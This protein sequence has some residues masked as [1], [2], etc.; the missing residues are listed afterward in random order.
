VLN[1]A[2]QAKREGGRLE[3]LYLNVDGRHM[4]NVTENEKGMVF[5]Q[6]IELLGLSPSNIVLEIL[7]GDIANLD[8][9]AEIVH[10]YKVNGY[11]IAIDDFGSKNSNFDRLWRISPNIVKLDRSLIVKASESN[12]ARKV[13][14]KII[15]T[16]HELDC[17][18]VVEGI[19]TAD[20]HLIA[21]DAGA[22]LLQ[23]FLYGKPAQKL[24]DAKPKTQGLPPLY[25]SA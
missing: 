18:T 19:E 11:R 13:M 7:E 15:E 9:L 12:K 24:T 17:I 1:Y 25:S 14:K 4:M 22:D 6:M 2:L 3:C 21:I 16:I 5:A 8:E 10:C 20:Q 23:G